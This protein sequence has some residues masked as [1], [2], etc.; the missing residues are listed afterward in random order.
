MRTELYYHEIAGEYDWAFCISFKDALVGKAMCSDME[1]CSTNIRNHER[2]QVPNFLLYQLHFQ[3]PVTIN[4]SQ[5]SQLLG[6]HYPFVIRE[7]SRK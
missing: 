5:E 2:P 6:F 4:D 3:Q 7:L 1:H